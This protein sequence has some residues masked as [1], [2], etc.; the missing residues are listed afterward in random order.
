MGNP[1]CTCNRSR[2]SFGAACVHK[3]VLQALLERRQSSHRSF[4]K[5]QRVVEAPC[6]GVGQRVFGVYWNGGS[7]SP[8][9][10]MV[11]LCGGRV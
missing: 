8:K 10:T 6:S 1:S 7:T 3:L 11:H 9:R 2:L 4:Q 5:G